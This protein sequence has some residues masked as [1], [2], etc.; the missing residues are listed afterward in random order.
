MADVGSSCYLQTESNR[1]RT[2][3]SPFPASSKAGIHISLK[4]VWVQKF[5][6]VPGC[7][8]TSLGSHLLRVLVIVGGNLP[9]GSLAELQSALTTGFP[10]PPRQKEVPTV[11]QQKQ[12]GKAPEPEV[13]PLPLVVT[14]S[15]CAIGSTGKTE[16]FLG[17]NSCFIKQGEFRA[18][19]LT[20]AFQNH[21]QAC[22]FLDS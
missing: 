13:K 16:T 7:Q 20:V 17:Y 18:G 22:S 11:T 6:E 8:G 10:M 12:E 5:A 19:A 9:P 14:L 1:R 3:K 21:T 4:R 2:W 15:G